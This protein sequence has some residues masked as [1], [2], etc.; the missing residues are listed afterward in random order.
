MDDC[1][2]VVAANKADLLPPQATQQRLEVQSSSPPRPHALCRKDYRGPL[3]GCVPPPWQS[4][5][6]QAAPP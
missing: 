5:P 6:R 3:L 2:L 1:R 4:L